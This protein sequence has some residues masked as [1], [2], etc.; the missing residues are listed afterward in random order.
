MTC[1]LLIRESVREWEPSAA[2]D[3][4]AVSTTALGSMP[5]SSPSV[6]VTIESARTSSP[7]SRAAMTS[8]TVDMP[9]GSAPNSLSIAASARVS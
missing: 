2:A 7:S 5:V 4:A 9:T 8:R 1:L 6:T 3:R